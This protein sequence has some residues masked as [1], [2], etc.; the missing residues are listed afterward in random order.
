MTTE[1]LEQA[2]KAGNFD[3]C[4]FLAKRLLPTPPYQVA[5]ARQLLEPA[6]ARGGFEACWDL[7]EFLLRSGSHQDAAKA[8]EFLRRATQLA[9]AACRREEVDG[10]T[11]LAWAYR[12]GIGVPRDE[13]K[14]S[15]YTVRM[16]TLSVTRQTQPAPTCASM[17][18]A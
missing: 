13:R 7:G 17:P 8:A 14:A 2:C 9:E 3:G 12:Y 18:R 15:E 16:A 11:R 5:R 10:C 6:C 1:M 4:P